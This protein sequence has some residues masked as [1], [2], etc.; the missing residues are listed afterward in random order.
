MDGIGKD[1]QW[2]VEKHLLTLP[3]CYFVLLPIL[4]DVATFVAFRF[5]SIPGAFANVP[6][7][8]YTVAQP[9]TLTLP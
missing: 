7:Q 3:P 4:G 8:N 1:I 9:G 5:I 6:R 2:L